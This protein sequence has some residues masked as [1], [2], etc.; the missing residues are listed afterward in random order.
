LLLNNI[1][2]RFPHFPTRGKHT[3]PNVK[4]DMR[5]HVGF[6]CASPKKPPY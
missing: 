3:I 5:E 6:F 4:A 2:P 1:S